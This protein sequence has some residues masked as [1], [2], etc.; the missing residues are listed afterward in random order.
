[1]PPV[2][3]VAASALLLAAACV[4]TFQSLALAADGSFQLLRVLAV[5]DLYATHSRMLGALARQGAV[6]I[7]ARAG[8]T[9]THQLSILL[10]VGQLL[11]PA[12]AW[13]LAI[14]LSRADRLACAAVTMV[15]GLSAGALGL[16][17]RG[18]SSATARS[19]FADP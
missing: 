2:A 19:R 13:A 10:G 9:D 4:M 6:V 14:V 3:V 15:A 7:A 16:G 8:V 11:V 18:Y 1:M 17:T 5:D 12:I